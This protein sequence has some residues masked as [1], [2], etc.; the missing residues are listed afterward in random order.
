MPPG[1]E[2][3][4]KDDQTAGA[5][6]HDDDSSSSRSDLPHKIKPEHQQPQELDI[7]YFKQ[8]EEDDDLYFKEEKD[9]NGATEDG[10]R[11]SEI[12]LEAN[13]NMKVLNELRERHQYIKDL[14]LLLENGEISPNLDTKTKT[15]FEGIRSDMASLFKT[16]HL[17]SP[18]QKSARA[19]FISAKFFLL[20]LE[21]AL[22]KFLDRMD[23]KAK[24][25]RFDFRKQ[26]TRSKSKWPLDGQKV[27]GTMMKLVHEFEDKW[28]SQYEEES[29]EEIPVPTLSKEMIAS[30]IKSCPK[31]PKAF[32]RGA[33]TGL[34]D[35]H[36]YIYDG[37]S[38]MR[39]IGSRYLQPHELKS[40]GFW[41]T[42]TPHLCADSVAADLTMED[43]GCGET[44][45]SYI[46]PVGSRF[47]DPPNFFAPEPE[48]MPTKMVKRGLQKEQDSKFDPTCI[49]PLLF[50]LLSL[51][52]ESLCLLLR[53]NGASYKSQWLEYFQCF[54]VVCDGLLGERVV[55][56]MTRN[57]NMADRCRIAHRKSLTYMEIDD[58]SDEP[59]FQLIN[60]NEHPNPPTKI[61]KN[62]APEYRNKK[63]PPFPENLLLDY[64]EF[65]NPLEKA[66]AKI[67]PL[68]SYFVNMVERLEVKGLVRR[69]Q[70]LTTLSVEDALSCL[71][72][73]PFASSVIYTIFRYNWRAI[74][75][76]LF[77][78]PTL[79]LK[80]KNGQNTGPDGSLL[81]SYFQPHVN[82][83]LGTSTLVGHR[84][85]IILD[86]QVYPSSVALCNLT[87]K[88]P[89]R[90]LPSPSTSATH[91]SGASAFSKCETTI[92]GTPNPS[93]ELFVTELLHSAYEEIG[94]H[95]I[96]SPMCHVDVQQIPSWKAEDTG[97]FLFEFLSHFAGT[98]F[99]GEVQQ[100]LDDFSNSGADLRYRCVDLLVS[101]R[102]QIGD[103]KHRPKQSQKSS[104][105]QKKGSGKK[106]EPKDDDIAANI[107]ESGT[108]P[109]DETVNGDDQQL[110]PLNVD[111][112][113]E[114]IYEALSKMDQIDMAN[115]EDITQRVHRITTSKERE[116][117]SV[118][119]PRWTKMRETL[120]G[121]DEHLDLVDEKDSIQANV[122]ECR[123]RFFDIL[124][125]Q[126]KFLLSVEHPR[127]L[128]CLYQES[129]YWFRFIVVNAATKSRTQ[130]S[131]F[132]THGRLLPIAWQ[133][134]LGKDVFTPGMFDEMPKFNME[135][136]DSIPQNIGVYLCNAKV[137]SER[138]CDTRWIYGGSATGVCGEGG[139]GPIG[140]RTRMK[141][142]KKEIQST[143]GSLVHR[144][145]RQ[146]GED[147]SFLPVFWLPHSLVFSEDMRRAQ[148]LACVFEQVL[149]VLLG[150][151]NPAPKKTTGF[152]SFLF[153]QFTCDILRPK[154][155]PVPTW[156]GCNKV[157]PL[158]QSNIPMSAL[159]SDQIPWRKFEELAEA[160]W[161][162]TG[163][164]QLT[165]MDAAELAKSMRV[166]PS[167]Y[168]KLRI[169]N[170]YRTYLRDNQI[171]QGAVEW[172]L[173]RVHIFLWGIVAPLATKYGLV[174]GPIDN[175]YQVDVAQVPWH[176]VA[177]IAREK[178]PI[179]LI[180]RFTSDS[181]RNACST[182]EWTETLR[183]QH[184][185]PSRWTTYCLM[186]DNFEALM[187]GVPEDVDT[188]DL[189]TL[190]PR[191]VRRARE[192]A[193]KVIRK[194]AEKK[195]LVQ[196]PKDD[197]VKAEVSLEAVPEILNDTIEK[198]VSDIKLD[199]FNESIP[200][201]FEST[202]FRIS[203]NAIVVAEMRRFRAGVL[204]SVWTGSKR[205]DVVT[206]NWIWQSN[207]GHDKSGIYWT[208]PPIGH[209]T[210][211]VSEDAEETEHCF[212]E[213]HLPNTDLAALKHL[214]D[215]ADDL[216]SA[217]FSG[218]T[219]VGEIADRLAK[220]TEL[221]STPR[222]VKPKRNVFVLKDI[223]GQSRCQGLFWYR[224][225]D[226]NPVHA[227]Q[228]PG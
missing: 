151:C 72:R 140:Y 199:K 99:P 80:F 45:R 145:C 7:Q 34:K 136:L 46:K 101:C 96:V 3:Q 204:Q 54:N 172:S 196:R 163:H 41:D 109:G 79:A 59:K 143:R 207:S 132:L 97:A 93:F 107:C 43:L 77:L 38:L 6:G 23:Q 124:T 167:R 50:A 13:E 211:D 100:W 164:N 185:P 137:P 213:E 22:A 161:Q 86:P 60:D 157:F 94:D 221:D 18:T 55:A 26:R 133:Y 33:K 42:W 2:K 171:A 103:A 122:T 141:L 131:H 49:D 183:R 64:Q 73:Q 56:A 15:K 206:N 21:D 98:H 180:E 88:L 89:E 35:Q 10:Q 162:N 154:N 53:F 184:R 160:H 37:E 181:C 189:N 20:R 173:Q 112:T 177:W 148:A 83:S 114:A 27:S 198:L 104:K 194:F 120:K 11:F 111:K 92:F 139:K 67:F 25:A 159:D 226:R 208:T 201:A 174:S 123:K 197:I 63:K 78:P 217:E 116:D 130:L 48:L 228:R 81:S 182:T 14:I 158:F 39:N 30:L 108:P 57:W 152:S 188:R 91:G 169:S 117:F 144:K 9:E 28:M 90:S 76:V 105:K 150:L 165:D 85:V 179:D 191:M 70:D 149:C 119:G 202:T 166:N 195:K 62:R 82:P 74:G 128:E 69:N 58:D 155:L 134:L 146:A 32:R 1:R 44:L 227:F 66:Y 147:W 142:H 153:T 210:S 156:H 52:T 216:S 223:A 8:E 129:R 61:I 84:K 212:Q 192:I 51:P 113:T 68:Q 16:K 125:L 205:L 106:E 225:D 193:R 219:E 75:N 110:R 190:P 5:A 31:I 71:E 95:E 4:L 186:K 24:E 36:L 175:V 187:N 121:P 127:K 176:Q 102:S 40:K 209:G 135:Q 19:K 222:M 215:T 126:A 203:V 47:T 115:E 168:Y 220:A 87:W 214:L 138:G 65:R 12:E 178:C 224:P 118:L 200:D 29:P 170:M 17:I 218:E